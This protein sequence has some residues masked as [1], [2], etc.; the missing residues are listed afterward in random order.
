MSVPQGPWDTPVR[1]YVKSLLMVVI[2]HN[3]TNDRV[4]SEF[5]ID[6]GN[7]DDRKFLGR[8][9]FWAIS[10]GRSVECISKKDYDNE[11]TNGLHTKANKTS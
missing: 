2:I 3:L 7:I 8:I 5:A 10:N 1:E 11:N 6:Y 9:S 4:E